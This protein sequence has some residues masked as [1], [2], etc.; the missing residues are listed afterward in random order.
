MPRRFVCEDGT[1]SVNLKCAEVMF[2][3]TK[4]EIYR[5]QQWFII[6]ISHTLK[7][8]SFVS[9]IFFSANLCNKEE[10]SMRN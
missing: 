10:N 7:L 3:Y 6:T 2:Y 1:M 4:T 5:K 8:V 9:L